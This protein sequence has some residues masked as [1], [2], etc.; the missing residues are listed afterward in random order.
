MP[1]AR[2]EGWP[3]S[4]SSCCPFYPN[5]GPVPNARTHGRPYTHP[6][7]PRTDVW[8]A[9]QPHMWSPLVP[10]PQAPRAFPTA[11]GVGAA[12]LAAALLLILMLLQA[13]PGSRHVLLQVTP[14]PPPPLS[15]NSNPEEVSLR[16]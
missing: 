11:V 13:S 5:P 8:P 14:P 15:R 9:P 1:A 3:G 6:P 7:T 2:T 4:T 12:G 10:G 16:L